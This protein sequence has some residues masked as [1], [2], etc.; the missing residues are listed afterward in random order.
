MNVVKDTVL[1]MVYKLHGLLFYKNIKM[2]T[3]QT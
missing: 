1:E 2:K 3:L